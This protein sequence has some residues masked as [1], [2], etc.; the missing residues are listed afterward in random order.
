[1]PVQT[2]LYN[3]TNPENNYVLV[4]S[5]VLYYLKFINYDKDLFK[6]ASSL[7]SK[8]TITFYTENAINKAIIDYSLANET[9][10]RYLDSFFANMT[11][12]DT[13]SLSSG[14]YLDESEL[15]ANLN[16]SCTF[17][18]YKD[19]KIFAVVNSVT[20]QNSAIDVYFGDYFIAPPQISKSGNLGSSVTTENYALVNVNPKSDKS[21][22]A[23]GITP[24]DLIE[25]V[26]A[27]SG[28]NQ[29]KYE[30]QE[31]S[32]VKNKEVVRIKP[33]N[34][35]IPIVESLIG[36]PALVNVYVKG[37]PS[38]VEEEITSELGCC[39]DTSGAIKYSNQ[40]KHQCRARSEDYVFTPGICSDFI[41]PLPV[42]SQIQLDTSKEKYIYISMQRNGASFTTPSA[43]AFSP[44]QPK[45]ITTTDSSG[46]INSS[47]VLQLQKGTTYYFI[48]EDAS[49]YGVIYRIVT[50]GYSIFNGNIVS[51]YTQT[52]I[53]S[54]IIFYVS[55]DISETEL[56]LQSITVPNVT[57][58]RL[59]IV[60]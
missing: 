22:Q 15:S 48:L 11:Q 51:N 13:F 20:N 54:S 57:P 1:M 16:S 7:T 49:N 43:V 47:G 14:N 18:E 45:T 56:F 50:A 38:Y 39:S 21:L 32:T 58:L 19:G 55:E 60:N 34:S 23:L 44:Q 4:R 29:I 10:K 12:I 8:P 40:T 59:Q 17:T 52:G 37:V 3:Y 5:E 35:Q 6:E 41:S 31:I 9:D 30:I 42:T 26:K 25:I 28:N 46:V 2:S 53:G 36:S 33:Y 27:G 24:G